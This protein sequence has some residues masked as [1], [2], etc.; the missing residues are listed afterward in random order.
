M[1]PGQAPGKGWLPAA[2]QW[3]SSGYGLQEPSL[4]A[5]RNQP[6]LEGE[7]TGTSRGYL[8]VRRAVP[9]THRLQLGIREDGL[10]DGNRDAGKEFL[11]GAEP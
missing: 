1:H 2:H 11:L 10:G 5:G 3:A 4:A 7:V 6:R 8:N 9:E